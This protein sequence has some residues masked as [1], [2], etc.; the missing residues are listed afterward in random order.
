M[1]GSPARRTILLLEQDA[2]ARGVVVD[3]NPVGERG[4]QGADEALVDLLLDGGEA[5]LQ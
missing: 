5:L 4:V 2:R 1:T 3:P